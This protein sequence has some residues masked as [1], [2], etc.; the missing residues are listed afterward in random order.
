[1]DWVGEH[2]AF[3]SSAQGDLQSYETSTP[4]SNISD[5]NWYD[6]AGGDNA[7]IQNT[8]NAGGSSIFPNWPDWELEI[9]SVGSY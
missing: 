7:N 5:T 9:V 2:P 1:M 6:N 8:A 4:N 3:P